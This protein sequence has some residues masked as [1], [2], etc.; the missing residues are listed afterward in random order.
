MFNLLLIGLGAYFAMKYMTPTGPGT[1]NPTSGDPGK[2]TPAQPSQKYGWSPIVPP[3]VDNQ[4]QPWYQ[5]ISDFMQ[6]PG[7]TLSKDVLDGASSTQVKQ[8]VGSI[9]QNLD[10]YFGGSD[11]KQNLKASP[12]S[13]VP[14]S[15]NVFPDSAQT[16][17]NITSMEGSL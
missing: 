17:M 11:A 1:I 14:Q 4:S 3:R 6:G 7:E 8:D 2:Y 15:S 9:W 10:S 16:N 5:G 13:N 12:K